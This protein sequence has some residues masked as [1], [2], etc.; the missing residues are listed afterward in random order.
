MGKTSGKTA[1]KTTGKKRTLAAGMH[2][3][4]LYF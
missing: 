3:R 2:T 1:G 4:V